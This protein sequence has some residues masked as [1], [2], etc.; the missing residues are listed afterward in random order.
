MKGMFGAQTA[1]IQSPR[2]DFVSLGRSPSG[3]LYRKQILSYGSFQHPN[4]PN[5]KLVIDRGLGETLVRNF[6]DGVC[7]IV[8]VPVV[9]RT[10]TH[11]EDP[12]RN[13]GEVVDLTVEDDGVYANIDVR[14]QSE[15]IGKTLLG[16]SAMM[17]MDYTDTRTGQK[18][19]PTL[20]H[21]A[22][23]NRPYITNLKG[24]EDLVAAS[25][26]QT[27]E[28]PG[29]YEAI[30]S[31]EEMQMADREAM[32]AALRDEYGID[33]V[34]LQAQTDLVT[35]LSAVLK[36]AGAGTA[37]LEKAEEEEITIQDVAEAVIE[38]SQEKIGLETQV[39]DLLQER[40]AAQAAAAEREVDG[41][42]K[43]GRVL[44][45]QR[46][47]MVGLARTDRQTFEA[48]IPDKAVVSLSEDGVT[49]H[50]DGSIDTE[51]FDED[52]SRLVGLANDMRGGK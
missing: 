50:D 47:A 29:F 4:D 31:M 8:Q 20:L 52:V 24:F 30:G 33:V 40:E 32:I 49:V 45:K 14:K 23:T 43:S 26:D 35:A 1:Y 3:H 11:N 42:I 19:G 44:P 36:D 2:A 17:H 6:R 18:V 16:V 46:E 28:E 7:D 21:T 25:A 34:G 10:N 5:D 27:G 37:V 39:H 38:L 22:I 9:D 13:I 15:D 41:L 12:L 51:K 48:L